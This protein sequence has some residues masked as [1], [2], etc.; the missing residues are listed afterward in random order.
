MAS[1][2]AK[3]EPSTYS[4]QDLA[5]DKRTRWDGVRNAQARNNLAAMRK[6]DEVLIYHSGDERAVVGIA[7]VAKAPYPDPTAND[8]RWVCVDLAAKK[9]LTTP[10]VLATIKATPELSK[11]ALVKHSRLSVMPVDA[12]ELRTIIALG[13]VKR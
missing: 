6:G 7:T 3:T 9:P 11:M 8:P 13:G 5:R 12:A 2:L 10:V 1:W 4:W